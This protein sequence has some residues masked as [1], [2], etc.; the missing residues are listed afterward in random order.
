MNFEE[1]QTAAKSLPFG[2]RL[3]GD[4]YFIKDEH[5][6]RESKLFELIENVSKNLKIGGEFNIIKLKLNEFK[7]SF[8]SYP[9]FISDPHPALKKS[10]SIDLVKGKTRE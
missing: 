5:L 4:I 7:I 2:K 6:K 10:I 1:Y 8:L 3:P 9:D